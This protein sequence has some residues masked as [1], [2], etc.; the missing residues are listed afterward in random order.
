MALAERWQRMII[1]PTNAD[2][3]RAIFLSLDIF[4]TIRVGL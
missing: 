1:R 2:E 3:A 4:A